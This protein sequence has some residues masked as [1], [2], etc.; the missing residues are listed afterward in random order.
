MRGGSGRREGE[1]RGATTAASIRELRLEIDDAI[2]EAQ[3]D[4]IT[5]CRL[6]AIGLRPCGGPR[7]YRAYSTLETDSAE[8]TGLVEAYDR[9]DRQ[10]NEEQGLVS[11]CEVLPRPDLD[12]RDGRC[13]TVPR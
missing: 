8:L 11:T 5:Q 6:I 12:L 2:G 1:P 3:A 7:A 13:V 9:L 4:G 10:R